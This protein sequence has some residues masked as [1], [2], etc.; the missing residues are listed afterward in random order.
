MKIKI[1]YLTNSRF[2]STSL[3]MLE[4]LIQL[5]CEYLGQNMLVFLELIDI[6]QFEHAATSCKSHHLLKSILPYSPP[7]FSKP[8][9]K[10]T[11]LFIYNWF[12]KR[13]CQ[14]QVMKFDV[15]T[16]CELDIKDCFV[17]NIELV[18]NSKI[19]SEKLQ[20]LKNSVISQRVTS[21]EI[22]DDQDP[23]VM[24]DLFSLLC[25]SSVRSLK[26][27]SSNLSKWMEHI[28]QIGSGLRELSILQWIQLKM[29][30][31][32]TSYCPYLEK[33]SLFSSAG[34]SDDRDGIT[35]HTIANN[36][37][38]IRTL[39]IIKQNYNT[40]TEADADLTA[41][42]EKCPQLE[43]LSLDCQQLTDQSVIAL[44]QH[45][46]RLKKLNL[47]HF[48]YTATSLIA[49]S[50]CGLPLEELH[51]P[52]IPILSAEIAVQCAHALSRI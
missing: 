19:S 30:N 6:I 32:I 28:S 11:D 8:L 44:A 46:S 31:T 3:F 26:I 47:Y 16:L 27:R 45:C 25:S 50:E 37:P 21:M 42:A 17:V 48:N 18:I 39:E 9:L 38:H 13:H 35:L 2:N 49:L 15:E 1:R 34:V 43:E 41:F 51:I 24:G 4:Y 5:P 10:L 7:I 23:A 14:V 29:L 40:S 33:L 36:C 12:S 52:W 22:Q 20:P